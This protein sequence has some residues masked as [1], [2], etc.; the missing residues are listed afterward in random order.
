MVKELS[1]CLCFE[2][3]LIAIDEEGGTVERLGQQYGFQHFPAAME[4]GVQWAREC[5][6]SVRSACQKGFKCR[7][8]SQFGSSSGLEQKSPK[9]DHRQIGPAALAG[10]QLLNSTP[11][12]LYLSIIDLAS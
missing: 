5:R 6:T 10:P 2:P 1:Q 3:P 7:F 11:G 12:Y 8:Q 4:Y 9:S